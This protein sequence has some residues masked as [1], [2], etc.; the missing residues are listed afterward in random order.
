MPNTINVSLHGRFLAPSFDRA[1]VGDAMHP[2]ILTCERDA[3]RAEL[4]WMM[5]AHRVHCVV[6]MAQAKNGSRDPRVWGIV[7]DL[8]LLG[9][10]LDANSQAT[11]GDLASQPIIS[12]ERGTPLPQAAGLMHRH[13]V[14]HLVVTDAQRP[15]GILSSLDIAQVL[16][17]DAVAWDST[18]T[19]G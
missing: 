8:D 10:A 15:I 17:A 11:A 13:G 4:A 6:V 3:N 19:S 1:S 16:A 5:A 2:G 18:A 14:S 12:V 7:S 9:S